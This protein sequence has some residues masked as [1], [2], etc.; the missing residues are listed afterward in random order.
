MTVQAKKA[1]AVA[2]E[3]AA[4]KAPKKSPERSGPAP[5]P[6]LPHVPQRFELDVAD[7]TCPS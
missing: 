5:Q 6:S 7:R 3:P 2:K 1:E 4:A